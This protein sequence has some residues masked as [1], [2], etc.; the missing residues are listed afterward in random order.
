[1]S[2]ATHVVF[3]LEQTQN[4]QKKTSVHILF[5][6]SKGMGILFLLMTMTSYTRI[7]VM[8]TFQGSLMLSM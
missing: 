4:A 2:I 1:M 7:T 6:T 8:S 3:I 5:T